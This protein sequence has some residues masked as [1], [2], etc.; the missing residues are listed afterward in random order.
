M[1]ERS[2]ALVHVLSCAKG[3]EFKSRSPQRKLGNKIAVSGSEKWLQLSPDNR[4]NSKK[5][6]QKKKFGSLPQSPTKMWLISK[7]NFRKGCS[8][9]FVLFLIKSF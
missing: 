6:R 7:Y 3:L 1:A 9:K 5:P 8:N 2:K 4:K